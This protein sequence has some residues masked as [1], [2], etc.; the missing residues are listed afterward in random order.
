M[1]M[2]T[3]LCEPTRPCRSFM[4]TEYAC[5]MRAV[6]TGSWFRHPTTSRGFTVSTPFYV[7]DLIE[8]KYVLQTLHT[9]GFGTTKNHV[10]SL[11]G[12][13]NTI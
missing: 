13:Q 4:E 1:T 5:N 3:S 11:S 12:Q 2:Y 10:F 7:G 6:H 8:T 9:D